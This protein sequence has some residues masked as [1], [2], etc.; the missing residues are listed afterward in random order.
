MKIALLSFEYP[1]ETGFGGIGTYTW[2]HARALAKLGHEVHVLAGAA[3][4]TTLRRDAHD[5]VTVHRFRAGG[6]L[7]APLG[8]LGRRRLWWTKNRI[9]N[10]WSMYRGLSALLREHRFDVVEMPECGA[11]GWLLNHVTRLPTVVRFHS[12][13][14]LIMG[15]YDV[16][17]ADI[18]WCSA[19]ERLAMR[20]ARAF[21]SCSRFLADE[22]RTKLGIAAAIEVIPNGIDLE[23]F[24]AEED[25]FDIRAQYGLPAD[26]PIV[27]FTG[28][29]EAR[30]GIHLCPEIVGSI[31]ERRAVSF[32]FAGRDLFGYMK[33]TLLPSVARRTLRG[34]VHHLGELDLHGVRSCLRQAEVFFL[35]SLWENCPYSVLEAMGAGKAIVCSDQGGMPELIRNEENG[36]LARSGDAASYIEQLNRVLDD[37]ALRRRLGS[38]ARRT[39]EASLT[40]VKIAERSVA[41]YRSSLGVA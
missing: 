16:P 27:L 13:A 39:V 23:L 20:G 10:G 8:V 1:V 38:A 35:P 18:R 26:Q 37:Q 29:M 17:A 25:R 33:D 22:V 40:D 2:Y 7:L 14:Q 19:V 5:G 4:P 11:E 15:S 32:V 6:A 12:P 3:A 9:E 30:K 41:F 24:D 21:S 28:R 36:L 31:L 34:S